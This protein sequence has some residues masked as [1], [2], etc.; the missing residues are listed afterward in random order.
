LNPFGKNLS[1]QRFKKSTPK[2]SKEEAV[3][4]VES[5][6]KPAAQ[7]A[8]DL[9]ISDSALY[10]WQK[11][12]AEKG[13]EASPGTGH[14]GSQYTSRAYR[15]CVRTSRDHHFPMVEASCFHF[16]TDGVVPFLAPVVSSQPE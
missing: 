6:S 5:S 12:L 3:K 10:Q 14:R 11:Q 7:I 1:W 4:L 9:G 2:D 15:G 13:P 16:S 8:R